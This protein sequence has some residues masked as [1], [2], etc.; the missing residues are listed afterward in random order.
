MSLTGISLLGWLHSFACA[1]AIVACAY[2]LFARKGT[3]R[4][5]LWGWWYAGAMIVQSLLVMGLYNFDVVPGSRAKPGPH[6]FGFFHIGSLL[7]LACVALALVS[8]RRQRDGVKW[9]LLHT[10]SM[11]FTYYMLIS[12]LINEAFAR[13]LVLR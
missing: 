12:A 9:A 2:V 6:I 1:I 11:L 8:A 10:Q 3:A 7:T 4:R 5:R 13:V